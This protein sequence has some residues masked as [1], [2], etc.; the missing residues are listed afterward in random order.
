MKNFFLSSLLILFVL[1]IFASC[2]LHRSNA[3]LDRS[4]DEIENS[5]LVQN[6]NPNFPMPEIPNSISNGKDRAI[7]LS[8]YY[9]EEFPFDDVSL[10]D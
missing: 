3:V 2:G 1:L 5:I 7:F 8:K 6:Y 9:W 10:I 4:F